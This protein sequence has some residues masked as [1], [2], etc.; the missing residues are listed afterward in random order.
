MSFRPMS[1][2]SSN[3]IDSHEEA[4]F[5]QSRA[6]KDTLTA[7]RQIIPDERL[8]TI[9]TGHPGVGK[10]RLIG[11]FAAQA[12]AHTITARVQ[13]LP[14]AAGEFQQRVLAAF[15]LPPAHHD[16]ANP[17]RTLFGYLLDQRMQAREVVLFIDDAHLIRRDMA[18]TLRVLTNLKI[19]GEHLLHI[20]LVGRPQLARLIESGSL[21]AIRDDIKQW[22]QLAPL[23]TSDMAGFVEA[24][25]STREPYLELDI[26]DSALSLLHRY[27]GGNPTALKCLI[28]LAL[29]QVDTRHAPQLI[30][31]HIWDGMESN[32]WVR[33]AEQLG[34]PRRQAETPLT[35]TRIAARLIEFRGG[36]RIATHRL[37]KSSVVVGRA[38]NCEI[39]ADDA[40]VSRTHARI[41]LSNDSATL[42]DLASHNGS[43]INGRPVDEQAIIDGDILRFG[44]VTA[45]FYYRHVADEPFCV[46]PNYSAADLAEDQ[47]LESVVEALFI[48][49]A[50]AETHTR[51]IP[52]S[53]PANETVEPNALTEAPALALDSALAE[54]AD[55]DIDV[56]SVSMDDAI[57]D[58]SPI[59]GIA[60]DIDPPP[61]HTMV[62]DTTSVESST[63]VKP[64]SDEPRLDSVDAKYYEFESD[65]DWFTESRVDLTSDDVIEIEIPDELIDADEI[66]ARAAQTGSDFNH[67]IPELIAPLANSDETVPEPD[68]ANFAELPQPILD[69]IHDIPDV[70]PNTA[71]TRSV[72]TPNQ[73]GPFGVFASPES[74]I[75]HPIDKPFFTIGRDADNDIEI[76]SSAVNGAH[77]LIVYADGKLIVEDLDSDIGTFINY[78]RIQNGPLKNGDLLRIGDTSFRFQSAHSDVDSTE[79]GTLRELALHEANRANEAVLQTDGGVP[80]QKSPT[81]PTELPISIEPGAAE[82]QIH[83]LQTAPLSTEPAP[84]SASGNLRIAAIWILAG[85]VLTG[86]YLVAKHQSTLEPTAPPGAD[87]PVAASEAA[88]PSVQFLLAVPVPPPIQPPYGN[89]VASASAVPSGL[90]GAEPSASA[91]T[92]ATA[93][94]IEP[95]QVDIA[96]ATNERDRGITLLPP[97]PST[98]EI[99][100]PPAAPTP[101]LTEG[102][103]AD[104]EIANLLAQAQRQLDSLKLTQP[105]RDNAYLSYQQVIKLDPGNHDAQR[106]LIRIAEVYFGMAE[107]QKIRRN[108]ARSLMMIEKGLTVQRNHAE[109]LRL[110]DEVRAMTKAQ[111]SE[112]PPYIITHE[113]AEVRSDSEFEQPIFLETREHLTHDPAQ[114]SAI[115]TDPVLNDAAETQFQDD[116]MQIQPLI[117]EAKQR[118]EMGNYTASRNLIEQ[119]L[120]IEPHNLELLSLRDQVRRHQARL[121]RSGATR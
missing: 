121:D 43:Y 70:I 88:G 4:F 20:V 74:G 12:G 38:P 101:E 41:S 116:Q 80:S 14:L 72:E 30:P 51:A 50:T 94:M 113:V 36:T 46:G 28:E 37:Q 81:L 35:D 57:P 111:L 79:L 21:Q 75:V 15:G 22:I 85:I 66:I 34:G 87:A 32:D 82:L 118:F 76:D 110:R 31:E 90:E 44:H 108:Y 100:T 24:M 10:T 17:L 98:P 23:Q 18:H 63:T 77:A 19:D 73:E 49:Q 78:K 42:R 91:P 3:E 45:L 6:T 25:L 33:C 52:L 109:L 83:P 117:T 11:A 9:L 54:D 120:G 55:S 95:L 61:E 67:A 99:V 29:R 69:D 5:I 7:L 13:C 16:P 103:G 105:T 60:F 53:E 93:T 26:S 112:A 1:N 115:A 106:G 59:E 2:D 92:S 62:L 104:N 107:R 39:C 119:G 47:R 96:T 8:L 64:S 102:L 89:A 56:G 97:A 65:S 86:L 48:A 40:S 68:A 114:Q 27:S 84:P 58:I 71:S